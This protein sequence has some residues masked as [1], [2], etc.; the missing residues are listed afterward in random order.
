MASELC[1]NCFS[2]KGQY[3]ICP[4]CGYAEGT[5]PE[6]PHYLQPGTILANHF[7]VGTAIGFGGFGITYKCFD[8]TLGV[9][10]AVKEF[11]P[12]G[13]VN[14]APGECSVGVLSGEKQEQYY[15]QLRRFLMEAQSIAQF[16]KAKDIVNVYDFFEANNTAYIIMEYVD[17]V[18]LKDYLERQGRMEP[19]TA[20]N[21]ITPIVEAVKKIHAKGII[22]R[23]ISPDNIFISD[24]RS[25][26]VFDFGAAELN[27]SS[28]GKAAE[29]VIKVGYSAPEQYRDNS[30]QGF[31]TDIYSVGAILYQMMTGIKPMESTEREFK[32]TLKSPAEL[33]VNLEPNV[34]RAIMEA[35]AVQPELRFQSI[36]QL[37]DAL[38]SKRI[39][40]YPKIKLRRRRRRRNWI[41][42]LSTALVL[43]VAVTI[44]LFS[45]VL[46]EESR[47]F[48]TTLQKDTI[49]IWV[50]GTEQ[51]KMLESV[52]KDNF[53][54]G[55]NLGE[56]VSDRVRTMLNDNEKIEV[57]VI[58]I[59][60]EDAGATM[61]EKLKQAKKD[62]TMP[63]LFC[64]DD[65]PNLDEY[66]LV[67]FEDNV[68]A[69]IEPE[70][71]LY[72][73]EYKKH[74][75]DQTEMPTGINTLLLYSKSY[76]G[77]EEIGMEDSSFYEENGG[78]EGRTVE[79]Q[80]LEEEDQEEYTYIPRN[81]VTMLSI[82][83]SPSCFDTIS[84]TLM[85]DDD[86]VQNLTTYLGVAKRGEEKKGVKLKE[87]GGQD[88]GNSTVSTVG[89]RA[90]L[91]GFEQKRSE[92]QSG[93]VEVA[94][95]QAAV[96]TQKDKMLVQ[97]DEKYAINADSSEN[98]KTACMR[99][100]W[101]LL[102]EAAQANYY[103]ANRVSPFPIN[104]KAFKEFFTYNPKFTC[105]QKMVEEKKSCI[106]IGRGGKTIDDFESGMRERE[107]VGDDPQKIREYCKKYTEEQKEP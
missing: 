59:T 12:T 45:T 46:K 99:F 74:F 2:V 26:K 93:Q 52:S 30:R 9:I 34:D 92:E 55:D 70:D 84:G 102:G 31:Y 54:A 82:L 90:V 75:P 80:A 65:V 13:L 24:E 107:K 67:S 33:G 94:D 56:G 89:Y 101:I 97:Y 48:D 47:I 61:E 103:P 8:T 106:L 41:I 35:L 78:E 29:K 79:L 73:T 36:Q 38:H 60:E 18:L 57:Q 50:S 10:V 91:Y 98:K 86:L 20:M 15:A 100:M 42:S 39:A 105:F 64:T 88:Y 76:K 68:L 95:C 7:I 104:S 21:I 85:P 28:D 37:D 11:Y 63:D 22:H 71:Y 25:V 43:A 53:K 96:L 83:K 44:G 66:D 81:G 72:M 49:T 69:E 23:D 6:Q 17:G 1:M 62:G 5:P 4:F 3:E 32:D 27:D 16:G 19:E 51:K 58:D 14:R 87:Y 40:E 77:N